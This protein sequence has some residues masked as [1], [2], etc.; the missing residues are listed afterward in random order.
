MSVTN[1]SE[2]L[3][4][5][6][7]YGTDREPNR[8]RLKKEIGL[9]EGIGVTVGAIIGSGLFISPKGIT[10]SAGSVGLSLIVWAGSGIISTIGAI[11]YAEL[12]TTFPTSGAD[13]HYLHVAFGDLP[14]FLY[15]WATVMVFIPVNYAVLALVC[16]QYIIIPFFGTDCILPESAI[17]IIAALLVSFL[18]FLNSYDVRITAKLQNVFLIAKIAALLVI[19]VTGMVAIANGHTEQFQDS[20]KDSNFDPGSIALAFY[21]GI[22]AYGGANSLNYMTEE[23]KNPN[24]NLP[25]AIYISLA[26][27][28]VIYILVNVA[29]FSVISPQEMI[30]SEATAITFAEKLLGSWQWTVPVFVA[31]ST[32]GGL[33]VGLMISA[34]ILFV[35]A[36]N[37]QFPKMLAMIQYSRLTP[38]PSLVFIGLLSLVYLFISEIY[39]LINY[40]GFLYALSTAAVIAGMLYMRWKEPQRLRPIKINISLPVFYLVVSLFLFVLPIYVAPW[41]AG[42][43]CLIVLTGIPVYYLLVR[44]K[45]LPQIFYK[46]NEICTIV[47]QKLFMALPED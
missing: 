8:V 26:I 39:T 14:A 3:T 7:N 33:S 41:E 30:L 43:G 35:G 10:E 46:C 34:R 15:L 9:F 21:S 1:S 11:C 29:Y 32:F 23:M 37:S 13:Y 25:W 45:N 31:I 24:R 44:R 22:Y 12:G 6:R 28:T 27:I 47:V 16:A 20:M 19:A 4:D 18:I 17:R 2:L 36:R 42:I 40:A 38:A 5:V